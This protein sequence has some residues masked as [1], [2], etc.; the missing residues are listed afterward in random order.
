MTIEIDPALGDEL[1]ATVRNSL[2]KQTSEQQSVFEEEYRRKRKDKVL[3]TVLAVVFPIHLFMLG[4]TGLGILYWITL[5]G[6]G[7]WWVLEWFLTPKR[8][9]EWNHRVASEIM[10]DMKI[11]GT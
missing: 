7:V 11:M 10:R 8:V 2:G 6:M 4:K 3:L 9:C 5:G 1:P